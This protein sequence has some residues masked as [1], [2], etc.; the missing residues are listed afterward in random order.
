MDER[1]PIVEVRNLVAHYG[2]TLILDD[3]SFQVQRGEVFLVIGGSGCGKTTLLKH[4]T[5]LLRPTS[6]D[7]FY[8]GAGIASMNEDE[9][10]RIQQG[11]GIAFQGGAL[12]NS[13]TVGE[14]VALP[15][16]EH[17]ELE[18]SIIEKVVKIKLELVGLRGFENLRPEELSGGMR[19]RVGLARE[20][21]YLGSCTANS[22]KNN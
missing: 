3:I 7:V 18:E 2:D 19:K 1:T 22:Q 16:R 15:L 20:K 10:A 6:G 17:S 4:M 21:T 8:E 9:L 11:I 5:G 14:N 13:M 12:F